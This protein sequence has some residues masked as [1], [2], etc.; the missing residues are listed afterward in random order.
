MNASNTIHVGSIGNTYG[1]L[2]IRQVGD[3]FYWGIT[4][5]GGVDELYWSDEDDEDISEWEEISID[6]FTILKDHG[7][8]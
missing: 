1:G 7:I 5:Y 3:K 6:L 2:V 4:G 8:N